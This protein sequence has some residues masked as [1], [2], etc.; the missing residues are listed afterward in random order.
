MFSV[1]IFN[2]KESNK[3]IDSKKAYTTFTDDET[4]TASIKAIVAYER[5]IVKGFTDEGLKD[6]YEAC[7]SVDDEVE[8]YD[9]AKCYVC[10]FDDVY[11]GHVYVF[12]Y[13]DICHIQ[14]IRKSCFTKVEGIS[15]VL[16]DVILKNERE[17]LFNVIE[18][19]KHTQHV[20]N[21]MGFRDS[22][23]HWTYSNKRCNV[24]NY[25]VNN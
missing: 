3:I 2:W 6:D 22:G 18:P 23:M 19:P 24:P 8:Q 12:N 10:L 1:K 9:K 17:G 14:G 5:N 25:R 20:L 16:I 7:F 4:S 21:D 13:S 15:Y 11:V